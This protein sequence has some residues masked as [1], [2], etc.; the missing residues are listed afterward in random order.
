MEFV[1]YCEESVYNSDGEYS[2]SQY[3]MVFK[4]D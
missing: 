1:G 3:T 4:E 2:Y